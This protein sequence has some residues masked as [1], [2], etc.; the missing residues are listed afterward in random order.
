[1]HLLGDIIDKC[2][3]FKLLGKGGYGSVFKLTLG[4]HEFAIKKIEKLPEISHV[5]KNE[6]RILTE[7]KQQRL[8]GVIQY[9]GCAEK[10]DFLYMFFDCIDGCDL[11]DMINDKLTLSTIRFVFRQLVIIVDECHKSGVYHRDLKPENVMVNKAG[12]VTLIDFGLATRQSWSNEAVGTPMYMPPETKRSEHHSVQKADMWSLGIVLYVM[13]FDM[14]PFDGHDTQCVTLD[15]PPCEKPI[16][17]I[18]TKLLSK[19]PRQR[20][21][22]AKL[23][24]MEW[25]K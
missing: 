5:L 17:N 13:M 24:T 1:M 21:S 25:M 12:F 23:L 15:I 7:I 4:E 22:C 19:S 8:P 10:D 18:L 14:F 2:E 20:P 3:T 6:I 9:Y 11:F 16:R